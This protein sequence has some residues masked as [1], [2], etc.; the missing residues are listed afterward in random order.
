MSL[1][2]SGIQWIR[3]SLSYPETTDV[4]TSP[5][6]SSGRFSG[7][8][9]ILSGVSFFFFFFCV[10]KTFSCGHFL[11]NQTACQKFLLRCTSPI[12]VNRIVSLF[13]I[14][15]FPLSGWAATPGAI[16]EGTR[17]KFRPHFFVGIER[18][19][20]GILS[21]AIGLGVCVC[22]LDERDRNPRDCVW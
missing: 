13:F 8:R 5:T 4:P 12:I 9:L 11:R 16:I 14:I 2:P 17:E 19:M 22:G 10:E 21:L 3:R 7:F 18:R 20:L 15:W 1:G 6:G